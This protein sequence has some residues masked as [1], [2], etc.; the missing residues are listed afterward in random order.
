MDLSDPTRDSH[1][2]RQAMVKAIAAE[3]ELAVRGECQGSLARAT[4]AADKAVAEYNEA[5]E[6]YR[7]TPLKGRPAP[8]PGQP[9]S[10]WTA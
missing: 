7:S 10:Q 5:V 8:A 2:L 1:P 3:H 6:R 9:R 4:Q